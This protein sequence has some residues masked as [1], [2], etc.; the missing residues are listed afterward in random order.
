MAKKFLDTDGL[1]NVW[2]KI[3]SNFPLTKGNSSGAFGY[4]FNDAWYTERSCMGSVNDGGVWYNFINIRHRGG[5]SDGNKYGIQIRCAFGSLKLEYREHDN[6]TWTDWKRLAVENNVFKNDNST[7]SW[8]NSNINSLRTLFAFSDSGDD[9]DKNVAF[10]KEG[11]SHINLV[12]DGS[13]YMNEGQEKVATEAFVN[14]KGY[15]TASQ[16]NTLIDNKIPTFSFSNGVLTITT[17]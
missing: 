8:A 11:D 3:K 4:N 9:G 16:V 17:H 1:T 13:F 6:G 7:P 10:S 14:N 12:I 5:E 2:G 15:Q